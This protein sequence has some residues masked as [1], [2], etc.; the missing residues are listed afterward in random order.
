MSSSCNHDTFIGRLI[1]SEELL[2]ILSKLQARL[3]G[4]LSTFGA[5]R[6]EKTFSDI[7]SLLD[8]ENLRAASERSYHMHWIDKVG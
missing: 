7:W 6:Q 5:V 3:P 8:G 2:R 4:F 1:L